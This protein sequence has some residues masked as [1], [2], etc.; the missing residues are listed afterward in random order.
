MKLTKAKLKQLIKEELQ[1]EGFMDFF[2][3]KEESRE[4]RLLRITTEDFMEQ[5]RMRGGEPLFDTGEYAD[6]KN[7]AEND[8]QNLVDE[9]LDVEPS[10]FN[11]CGEGRPCNPRNEGPRDRKWERRIRDLASQYNQQLK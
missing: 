4:D 2:R 7:Q 6:L 5:L 11:L 8:I 1:Q 3:K 9:M 10:E